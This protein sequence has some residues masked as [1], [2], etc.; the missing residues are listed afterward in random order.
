MA[1]ILING[2]IGAVDNEPSFTEADMAVF[3]SANHNDLEHTI[4]INSGGGFAEVGFKIYDMLRTSGKRITTIAH[5]ADSIASVIFLAGDIR[6]VAA[7]AKPL[8]H[9]P[10]IPDLYIEYATASEIESVQKA[11]KGIEDRILKIYHERTGADK[12]M[13]SVIMERNEPITA[14]MFRSLGFAHTIKS[15][16]PIPNAI[17]YK[18]VARSYNINFET[19]NNEKT[20]TLL[21]RIANLITK[22]VKNEVKNLALKLED[23]TPVWVMTEFETPANGDTVWLD[24]TFTTPAPDGIHTIEGGLQVATEAGVI[25]EVIQP[26]AKKD[27]D[28]EEYKAAV[29]PEEQTAI[30][31]EVMQ[32]LEPRIAA[33]EEALSVSAKQDEAVENLNKVKAAND[34]KL[35]EVTKELEDLKA[36]VLDVQNTPPA[37]AQKTKAQEQLEL[38]RKLR[39][40][41]N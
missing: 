40:Q 12:K 18:A 10:F 29:T 27:E 7:D 9:N 30:I 21:E 37:P 36:L 6:E 2:H 38:R 26:E 16:E 33:L 31:T 35:S 25:T 4:T 22:L 32:I 11:V 1:E 20:Q 3:L 15:V 8:I 5:Q 28:D 13:L 19:M 23:G 24:E 41:I 17:A 14:D 39:G 34:K